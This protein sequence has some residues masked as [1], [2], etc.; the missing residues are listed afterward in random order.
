MGVLDIGDVKIPCA[1]LEDGTRVLSETGIANAILRSRSGA[2]IRRKRKDDSGASIPIFL[3]SNALKPFIP[4]DF[5][6]GAPMLEYISGGKKVKGYNASILPI[7]CD[8]WLKAREAGALMPSQLNKAQNAEI[9]MRG[10]AHIG[11]IA[12]VDEATGY[13]YDR[14]RDA[15]QKI[16]KAYISEELLAWQKTFP[17]VF[18]KELFRLNGWDFDVK[19]VKK[20]PGV[21]GT[22]TNKL[23][24]EQLPPGVLDEL[25]KKTPKTLRGNRTNRY[26]QWLTDDFGSPHL[27]EQINKIVTL[28]Q[29][30]DNMK[31]MWQ[32]FEKLLERQNGIEQLELPYEFDEKG[33]TVDDVNQNTELQLLLDGSELSDFNQNLKKALDYNEKP[34][35]FN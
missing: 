33:R 7:V 17:D 34:S 25:K 15:L 3:T 1:V 27:K 26:F 13:Q 12:L 32:Q 16:L 14:E 23:I 21:I 9:L 28:F 2:A 29:L 11:I 31:H 19:G 10:L 8:V 18:Y 20:R 24:Y 4:Q 35:N 6:V 5:L 22:W 30:S